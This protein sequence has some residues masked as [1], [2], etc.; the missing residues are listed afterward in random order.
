MNPNLP[1]LFFYMDES[2]QT[3]D[4][5]M[6]VGGIVINKSRV[7]EVRTEIE[8]IKHVA[9]VQSEVKWTNLRKKTLPLYRGLAR[10]FFEL[11][12]D[13]KVRFHVIVC[14]FQNFNH[15]KNG[16]RG[17]SVSKM[18]YQLALHK[19]CIAYG[20]K[21]HLHIYPDN[22]E[23]ADLLM[24]FHHH[25]NRASRD[26]LPI[27]R[28]GLLCPALHM[29][30]TDSASE[31]LLQLNDIILGAVAYRRNQRN[32]QP[33]ASDHKKKLAKFVSEQAGSTLFDF[34]PPTHGSRFTVWPFKGSSLRT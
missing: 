24:P 12:A 34:N 26:H 22:G 21:A 19:G 5:Y 7:D 1:T 2:G 16:G 18:L 11:L 14:D 33:D 29:E 28:H 15:R 9:G 10:Y 4:R 8:R 25:M 20:E 6:C 32:L 17:Q 27:E 23:H 3:T 13:G 30:P 31:P